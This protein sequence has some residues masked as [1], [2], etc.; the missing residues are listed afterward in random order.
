MT[1]P[2]VLMVFTRPYTDN[3]TS[4]REKIN[5]FAHTSI[6]QIAEVRTEH[7]RHIL[8]HRNLSA[9]GKAGLRFIQGLFTAPHPLQALLFSD[10]REIERIER[11][12]K[13]FKPNVVFVESERS[14]FFIRALRQ[15]WPQLRIVCDVDDL[16]SRRMAEWSRHGHAISFGYMA[17]YI[18]N[19][20]QNLLAGPLAGTLCR[21]EATTLERIEQELLALCDQVV[22]L[23]SKEVELLRS[24]TPAALQSK[25]T[26]IPPACDPQPIKRPTEPLRFVFI[27][28]DALLQNRLTIEYLI[29]L[30]RQ[31]ALQTPLAIYGKMTCAY[32]DIPASVEFMGFA[33][34]LSSVYT[35][36]SILL[37]PSFV[38]GGVKTKIL[39][40]LEFGTLPIGNAI[41][42]EGI[43]ST[44][45]YP[46][47]DDEA[48][49]IAFLLDPAA[50]LDTFLN[51]GQKI[52]EEVSK[53]LKA[54]TI[55]HRWQAC[56]LP[57]F[58]RS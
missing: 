27:G 45:A 43:V 36:H 23:S 32:S 24:I 48:H 56:L 46:L 16:M 2:R 3:P 22:L 51:T 21:Y 44:N 9:V 57:D 18:P 12:V 50:Y 1:R 39:E 34:S 54:S 38:Q 55:S 11:I 42:F 8:A 4:G 6:S 40:A 5:T 29:G 58:A 30:W 47:I 19:A 14:Y 26:P 31:H 25:I 53:T 20:L 35:E 17:R 10:Q 15:R 28:S 52:S 41:S 7:F 49:L 33:E 13:S 37:S